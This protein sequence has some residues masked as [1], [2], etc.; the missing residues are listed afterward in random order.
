[1]LF[2]YRQKLLAKSTKNYNVLLDIGYAEKPNKYLG[3]KQIIGIDL[4]AVEKPSNYSKIVV[5][6]ANNLVNYFDESSID[7]ICCGELLEHLI[8]PIDFLKNC[9]KVLKPNGLLALTTPNP[10]H[11]FEFLSTVF[12]SK[13]IFYSPEHVCIYPQRW[14]IR[15][16]EIAGFADI[17]IMSGGLAIP[18]IGTIW[19]PRPIAE[20]TFVMGKAHK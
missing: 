1:M 16:F 5:G 10:H 13:K 4:H 9:N 8:N 18:I 14:L 3:N 15:M 19:F 7:A 2:D 20:F 17:K 6:N 12:L 11:L